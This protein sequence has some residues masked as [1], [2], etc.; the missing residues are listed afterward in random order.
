MRYPIRRP[1]RGTALAASLALVFSLPCLAD[2]SAASPQPV[3]SHVQFLSGTP[4]QVEML[5]RRAPQQAGMRAFK[6][7]E[8]GL[9]RE[10]TP[11]DVPS[12]AKAATVH[13][14]RVATANRSGGLSV[15]LDEGFMSN[16][17][18]RKDAAGRINLQ[19]VTGEDA[20]TTAISGQ[21]AKE[22]RHDR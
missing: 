8:T 14:A 3:A 20:A 5:S 10:A 17:V 22:H 21:A 13:P 1:A 7:P 2:S 18:A 19:C 9:F 11:E 15:M 16:T 12:T 6:D 4:A